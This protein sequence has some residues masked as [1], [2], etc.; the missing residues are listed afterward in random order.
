[1]EMLL[2]EFESKLAVIQALLASNNL[3]AVW[4]RKVSS[5]AWATCGAASFVNTASSEGVASLLLTPSGRYLICDNIEAP[6][7][8]REEQLLDQGWEFC[9]SP[10]HQ[11]QSQVDKMLAGLAWG[12]DG[13]SNG[14]QDLSAEISQL[15]SQLSPQERQ[16]MRAL[17]G[18]CAE[19]MR[20]SILAIRPG[21]SEFEIA[22]LLAMQSLNRGVNPIVNLVASDERIFHFRHPLPTHKQLEQ[23][24]MLVFCGRRHGLVCSL[25]RLMHYGKLPPALRLKMQAVAEVDATFISGTR[26]G[27][28][29]GEIFQEGQLAYQRVGFAD[30]WK[31]HHQGG[32]AGYEPREGIATPGSNQQVFSGQ[33]YA[34][35]PTISGVKS[36]DTILVGEDGNQTLTA[37]PDWPS[38]RVTVGGIEVERPD[39]LV[40]D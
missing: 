37:I 10:W 12:V 36:E 9:I 17:A 40:L 27:R 21:M 11:H 25:T 20:V 15:R 24:A 3:Q 34:W 29:W 38:I 8:E 28:K 31:Q 14:G 32:S 18:D 16:R 23:Y 35:N 26:P 33:A 4:L 22:G 30:E 7:L 2:L 39:I 5:F 6:R 1:M 19:A 13:F